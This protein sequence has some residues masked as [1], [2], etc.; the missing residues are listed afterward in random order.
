MLMAGPASTRIVPPHAEFLATSRS[1]GSAAEQAAHLAELALLCER[2]T[3]GSP[4]LDCDVYEALGFV[5]RRRPGGKAAKGG[6]LRQGTTWKSVG[7]I[8]SDTAATLSVLAELM[9]DA[10]WSLAHEPFEANVFRAEVAGERTVAAS[11]ALA[12]TAAMLRAYG[13]IA[14]NRVRAV[15][16]GPAGRAGGAPTG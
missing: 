8:T 1:S 7:R 13:R 12:L 2:A 15:K 11:A 14:N 16:L 10:P 3:A 6:I 4:G 5:V 9:P